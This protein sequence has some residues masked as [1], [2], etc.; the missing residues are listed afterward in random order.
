MQAHSAADRFLVGVLVAAQDGVAREAPRR[1]TASLPRGTPPTVDKQP[2]GSCEIA[3][4]K[5][6]ALAQAASVTLYHQ[7]QSVKTTHASAVVAGPAAEVKKACVA[8]GKNIKITEPE[9]SAHF[10]GCKHHMQ[11]DAAGTK[12]IEYDM[13]SF[14]SSCCDLYESLAPGVRWGE[15]KTPVIEEEDEE[16]E[17]RGPISPSENGFKCPLRDLPRKQLRNGKERN[18]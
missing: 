16:D 10:L 14:L 11:Q 15:V 5:M 8:I 7:L 4:T 17:C 3:Q 1:S 2:R 18:R 12:Y 13:E 9:Q 6:A